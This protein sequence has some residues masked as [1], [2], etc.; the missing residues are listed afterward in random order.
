[1]C[2]KLQSQNGEGEL[3][4]FLAASPKPVKT[5]TVALYFASVATICEVQDPGVR[6][7]G[8]ILKANLK[9]SQEGDR[10]DSAT[11]WE[12]LARLWVVAQSKLCRW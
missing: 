12:P 6:A 11:H 8:W 4:Y 9:Q 1:M 10:A 2:P 7:K 5:A 3:F